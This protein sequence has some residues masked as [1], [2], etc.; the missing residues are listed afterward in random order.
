MLQHYLQTDLYLSGFLAQPHDGLSL[1]QI[2]RPKWV[3]ELST[4]GRSLSSIESVVYQTNNMKPI[5][6][7]QY[8]AGRAYFLCVIGLLFFESA[9]QLPPYLLALR[10][11]GKQI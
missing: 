7:D 11:R 5:I 10:N 4:K 1:F 9:I 2:G 8:T 6:E 3:T